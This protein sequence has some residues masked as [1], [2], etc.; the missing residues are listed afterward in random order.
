MVLA[1][2]LELVQV[3]QQDLDLEGVEEEPHLHHLLEVVVV[4]VHW[5]EV[6]VHLVLIAEM[7]GLAGE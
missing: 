2:V 7:G 5:A 6:V 3:L 4:G 1:M